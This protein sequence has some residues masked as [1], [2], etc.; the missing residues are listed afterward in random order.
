MSLKR[1][2]I[3]ENSISESGNCQG[4]FYDWSDEAGISNGQARTQ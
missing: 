1:G 2:K 3:P 4:E